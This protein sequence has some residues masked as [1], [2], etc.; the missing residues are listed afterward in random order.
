MGRR[1]CRWAADRLPLLAGGEL[2]GLERRRAERHVLNCPDCQQRLDSLRETIATLQTVASVDPLETEAPSLWPDLA[3]QIQESRREPAPNPV[4]DR[5]RS[6]VRLGLAATVLI[7]ATGAGAWTLNR[8]YHVSVHVDVRPRSSA[9]AGIM[10]RSQV[11][12]DRDRTAPIRRPFRR[13]VIEDAPLIPSASSEAQR[14]T[15]AS[16]SSESLADLSESKPRNR[17]SA[18]PTR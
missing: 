4:C 15:R 7:A 1:T 6:W 5:L 14:P 8:H 11:A 13:R 2:L 9:T 16:S 10:G 17:P 12:S 3:L 18:E